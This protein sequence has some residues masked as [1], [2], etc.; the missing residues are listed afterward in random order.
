MPKLTNAKSLRVV[1]E[2][3]VNITAVPKMSRISVTAKKTP[4][5]HESLISDSDGEHN[6]EWDRFEDSEA[7]KLGK[8]PTSPKCPT[9]PELYFLNKYLT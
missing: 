9:C 7:C 5:H 6:R 8:I 2:A 1:S 3:I 4:K